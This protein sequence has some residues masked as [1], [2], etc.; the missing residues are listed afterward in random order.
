M[1]RGEFDGFDDIVQRASGGDD[2]VIAWSVDG[3]VV[4]RVDVEAR[5][6]FAEGLGRG[7]VVVRGAEV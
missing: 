3:L 4:A 2:E 5:G 1:L 6:V 7:I